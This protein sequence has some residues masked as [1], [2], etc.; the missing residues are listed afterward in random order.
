M[1]NKMNRIGIYILAT[2]ALCS[3]NQSNINIEG[4]LIGAQS[5]M[6]Y[7]DKAEGLESKVID[8]VSLNNNGE[9]QI[10]VNGDEDEYTLYHIVSGGERI[11]LFLQGGDNVSIS[12]MGGVT[13]NYRVEGSNESEILRKFYQP[14]VK[15]K[16]TLD[17]ISNQYA[18][19][20]LS[21][22]ERLELA[23]QYTKEYQT[24]KQEQ[25]RFIIENQSSLAAVYA[26][27]QRI[28]GDQY[29]FNGDN[30]V[31]YMRTVADALE[32]THPNST[33]LKALRN[34]ISQMEAG[35]DLIANMK[36][37]N[38]PDLEI[39]DMYGKKRKLSDEDG[40]VILLSFWSPNMA[41]SN[42]QNAELKS[43]YKKYK[44]QGFEI[45]Q[46]AIDNTKSRWVEAVQDQRLPWI[47]VCD[48]KGEKSTAITLYN[49][50]QLPANFLLSRS[51]EIVGR[52]VWGKDLDTELEELIKE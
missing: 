2:A 31:I 51:G 16:A 37:V 35:A 19:S 43:L 32:S 29:L 26:L 28:P 7:L 23:A 50:T 15:G 48:L 42:V 41:N 14:Y 17:N 25:L 20:E 44:D 38:Y 24:I 21:E 30:D 40:K 34:A 1:Q 5:S 36:S 33:Y 13:N 9:F 49:V 18:S 4:R 10:S 6:V 45:Y 8:S 3:C 46:V 11:P 47:S 52:D 12:A 39:V 27:Y 22:D